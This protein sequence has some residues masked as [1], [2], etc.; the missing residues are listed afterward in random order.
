MKSKRA[1]LCKFTTHDTDW[2]PSI[3]NLHQLNKIGLNMRNWW[4]IEDCNYQTQSVSSD[5]LNLFEIQR[6]KV[7]YQIYWSLLFYSTISS[8]LQAEC[9]SSRRISGVNVWCLWTVISWS[10]ASFCSL[11]RSALY[12]WQNVNSDWCHKTGISL[13]SSWN[14]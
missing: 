1:Q 5:S 10:N 9:N 13:E 11:L 8:S 6:Q 7:R 12:R 4:T 14:L 2:N 3:N